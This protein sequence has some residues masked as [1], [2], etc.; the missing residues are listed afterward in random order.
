[1]TDEQSPGDLFRQRRQ[2]KQHSQ[3]SQQQSPHSRR[4]GGDRDRGDSNRGGGGRRSGGERSH[5]NSRNSSRGHQQPSGPIEQGRIARL[6]DGYG[7]LFCASRPVDL[8]FHSSALSR[9]ARGHSFHFADLNVGD[10]VEF[11]VRHDLRKGQDA[12]ADLRLLEPGTVV[13]EEEVAGPGIRTRGVVER[14]AYAGRGGERGGGER[15]G[16]I[17]ILL[18]GADGDVA[19]TSEKNKDTNEAGGAPEEKNQGTLVR[20]AVSDYQPQAAEDEDE[21]EEDSKDYSRQ[22]FRSAKPSAPRL[23]RGDVVDFILVSNRRSN[24]HYG[25][26]IHLLQSERERWEQEREALL[27]ASAVEECGVVTS[28]KHQ[29]GFLRSNRRREEVYFHFGAIELPDHDEDEEGQDEEDEEY[30]LHEGACLSF[31]VVNESTLPEEYRSR[32]GSGNNGREGNRGRGGGGPSAGKTI[33]ARRVRFLPEGSVKFH[34]VLARGVTGR[35]VERPCPPPPPPRGGRKPADD[36]SLM[37]GGGISGKVHL[38]AP[39]HCAD[40]EVLALLL[41]KGKGDGDAAKDTAVTFTDVELPPTLSPGGAFA[42]SRD[43]S[44]AA[45]WV[46]EMDRLLFDVVVDCIDGRCRVEPTTC[47]LPAA[48]TETDIASEGKSAEEGAAPDD[49]NGEQ[50]PK[51]KARNKKNKKPKA[52]VRLIAPSLTGRAEGIVHLVKDNFGFIHLAERNADAYFRL[53]D[54]FPP[55]TNSDIVRF[56]RSEVGDAAAA[57]GKEF[58]PPKIT[59]GTEVSFDIF[60][61][62]GGAQQQPTYGGRNRSGIRDSRENVKAI[63]LCVLPPGTVVQTKTLASGVRGTVKKEDPKQPFAGTIELEDPVMRMS[64]EDRHPLVAKLLDDLENDPREDVSV[65]FHHLE[66]V[67]ENKVVEAMVRAR[68]GRLSL[69]YIP[70]AGGEDDKNPGRLRITKAPKAESSTADNGTSAVMD[71][72]EEAEQDEG[73]KR[74]VSSDGAN[75]PEGPE[76]EGKGDEQNRATKKAKE[77]TTVRYD[78]HSLP[79]DE[80]CDPPRLDDVITCDVVQSRRS[81]AISVENVRIVERK[82]KVRSHGAGKGNVGVVADVNGRFG[83]IDIV[84]DHARSGDLMFFHLSDLQAPSLAEDE[85]ETKVDASEE[86]DDASKPKTPASTSPLA[87][88]I[89]ISKGDEVKFDIVADAK[90]GKPIAKCVEI[91]PRGTLGLPEISKQARPE[92]TCRG[93]ILIE[94][95]HTSLANT[96]SRKPVGLSK[97]AGGRWANP[98]AKAG[99]GDDSGSSAVGQG[100]VLLLE[101]SAGLFSVSKVEVDDTAA[102]EGSGTE[103]DEA[104]T[105][106]AATIVSAVGTHLTYTNT[107]AG[108]TS[109]SVDRTRAPRRGDLVMFAGGKRKGGVGTGTVSNIRVTKPVGATKIR[110]H[111]SDISKEN[112]EVVFV[113]STSGKERYPTKFSEIV[114]CDPSILKDGDDVEGILHAGSIYGG[115]WALLL[116]YFSGFFVQCYSYLYALSISH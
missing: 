81:G 15:E 75:D 59:A 101:D 56:S 89:K 78:K 6:C 109:A 91:L 30:T 18:E 58:V 113:A 105:K 38:D 94:P 54:V 28:L 47:L 88:K 57:N 44:R 14:A 10:E 4:G 80:I 76:A 52:A 93:I 31:L 85:A 63:R 49:E 16:T 60:V 45:V 96:P 12:A 8:F 39:I 112:G 48:D 11:A 34:H 69:E 73:E 82:S 25:R 103:G 110:G 32:P 9:P 70:S 22:D 21:D 65:V 72:K 107:S 98:D 27:L 114:S 74:D 41:D 106:P 20:Y 111:L 87:G 77:I 29:F 86:S 33:S 79:N 1:M 17:R 66:S 104:K 62:P 55:E 24:L 68:K 19:N 43:G 53:Y 95:S 51:A 23:A 35:V 40:A 64:A 71:G 99:K 116:A 50:M 61:Q 102:G 5:N 42:T 67:Q 46:H 100:R 7:F 97:S 13:W 37:M 26:T 84:D 108:M 2:Q 83:F 90:T 115:K 92:I 36:A 3:S